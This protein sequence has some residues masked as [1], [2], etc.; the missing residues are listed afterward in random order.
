[1]SD[2]IAATPAAVTPVAVTRRRRNGLPVPREASGPLPRRVLTSPW[3]WVL[4]AM[5]A[6]YAACLW[7]Q[8]DMISRPTP[9][10]GGEVPGINWSA[11]REA[12]GLAAPTLAFWVVLYVLLD[13]FRP[14][15][16]ILWWLALGWGGA[17][18]T[19]ASIVINTWAA[20]QL[21]ITGNGDPTQGARAAV[22]VA[23][24]VEEATK[25]SILFLVAIAVRYRLV[26]TISAVVL[27]GLSGAGFAFTEN[28][29]YYGRAIVYSSVEIGVGDPEQAINQ[30]VL[31]RGV[32]L[33]FGH[34]LFT[35]MTAIGVVVALRSRSLL[36]RVLAPVTG[37]LTAA[38]LHMYFNF[39]AS[40][41]SSGFPPVT[42]MLMTYPLVLAF[43]LWVVRQL[44]A[45][46]RRIDARLGDYVR[47][48]WLPQADA[49]VFGRHRSRWWAAL[50]GLSHGWRTFVATLRLQ[51]A[52]T[53][54][55]YLRDAQ[56]RGTVDA[57]G[58][59]RARELIDR[60]RQLRPDAIS[61]PRGMKLH[62][63]KIQWPWR[64]RRRVQ[65]GWAP[66]RDMQPVGSGYAPPS[67]VGSPQYSPV[68]PRWGP[69]S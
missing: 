49:E 1:M 6:L 61:D 54:L 42:M 10:Q 46:G 29:I 3:T 7:F 41:S 30:L 50:V 40:V 14:Q 35:S 31:M 36:V 23:P 27:G 43:V 68:D 5:T 19:A 26:S 21:K 9:V 57:T 15:R 34:P 45:E 62:L 47:L 32:L 52:M 33:A 51:R 53:E 37:Y 12:A 66:P 25:A 28:I 39:F 38:L 59:L 65:Q 44:L 55:A 67:A 17:V 48:G 22:F 18:S 58:D 69:P 60:V 11:F 63:P 8:Y 64:R 13:R 16:P 2:P 24:F 56:V 20:E 4:I